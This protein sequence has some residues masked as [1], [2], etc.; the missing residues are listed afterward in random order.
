[1]NAGKTLDE[2]RAKHDPSYVIQTPQT[3][4]RRDLPKG[5]QRFIITSAQNGTPVHEDFLGCLL[6][7]ERH[8]RAEILV[9]PL[10]YKNPT[11]TFSGSQ[12]NAEWWDPR[13]TPY[14]W[15]QRHALN[16]NLTLL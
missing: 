8:L 15:N 1:M 5:T 12:Q 13:V 9:I 2:F 3:V 14:L 16:E 10:R 4:L 6:A 7:A 11:S